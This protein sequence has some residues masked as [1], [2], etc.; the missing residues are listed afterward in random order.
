MLRSASVPELC[1]KPR[2]L[3]L[4]IHVASLFHVVRLCVSLVIDGNIVPHLL[5]LDAFN[6]ES[7]EG[8]PPKFRRH[9]VIRRETCGSATLLRKMNLNL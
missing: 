1:G 6:D 8:R 9:S 2:L 3:L 5:Q 4:K 7:G